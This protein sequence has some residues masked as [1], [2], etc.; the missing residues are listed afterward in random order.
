MKLVLAE[1]KHLKDSIAIISELVTEAR[2]TVTKEGLTLTAMDPANVAMVNFKLLASSFSEYDP[3]ATPAIALNL[4]N[5]KQILRRAGPGDTLVLE[6]VENKL[7]V[8]IRG[9]S[10]R[11]FQLPLIELDD[12]EQRV[13]NLSFNATIATDALQLASAI[14]DADIVAESLAFI[15]EEKALTIAAEGD[16]S[17]ALIEIVADNHTKIV[18]NDGSKARARYSIEYLKKM[19][20]AA[21]LTEKVTIQF[22]KDY[23]LKLEFKVIDRLSLDFILAPR[24]END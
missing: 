16:L 17:R 4:L 23:P 7:K 20:Q 12:R 24:V 9:T 1:P 22:S 15:A 3:Q 10:T 5:L 11:T 21:K 18:V 2:F 14:D 13:P 19:I 8:V 6:T